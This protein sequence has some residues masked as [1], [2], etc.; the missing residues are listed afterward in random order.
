MLVLRASVDQDLAPLNA[1]ERI[2]L[3]AHVDP[4]DTCL[5]AEIREI[6]GDDSL[7]EY[8][9]RLLAASFGPADALD[10]LY[11]SR[12]A[13]GSRGLTSEMVGLLQHLAEACRT[14]LGPDDAAI[15]LRLDP[16]AR[17]VAKGFA[18][19]GRS[20]E[21]SALRRHML[22]G[23]S[24]ALPEAP[25]VRV[26][27]AVGLDEAQALDLADDVAVE[28]DDKQVAIVLGPASAL[29]DRLRGDLYDARKRVLEMG[30]QDYGCAL[31]A[32]IRLPR[33]LWREAHRQTLGVWVLLGATAASAV[34]VADLSGTHVDAEEL[35]S[36]L[37]GALAQTGARA[38]RYGRVIPYNDVW[39][40]D[41][42]VV[43]GITA[44]Q[45]LHGAASTSA[46]D[47]VVEATLVTGSPV[48]GFDLPTL[49]RGT[50]SVTTARSLGE[51]IE[52]G[53]IRIQ[54]GCRI[55]DEDLDDAG[56][57]R[58]LGGGGSCNPASNRPAGGRRPVSTRGP[59]GA[60]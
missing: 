41:T 2:A 32:A 14:F 57:L 9:D 23:M 3:A 5:Q 55:A 36:D 17:G 44:Q 25:L 21:R 59:H 39:T 37:A 11:T 20:S 26:I 24:I 18:A 33:G 38:Y 53:S 60:R 10:R 46:H 49:R 7:A 43:A 29:C 47:R 54:N 1:R 8:V 42:V 48:N 28:L 31:A 12:V 13:Q 56:S 15:E 4:D 40:R 51:L 27:S 16:R 45:A 6:A 34:M 35:A 19:V 52:N 22:D 58:V 50:P 30:G